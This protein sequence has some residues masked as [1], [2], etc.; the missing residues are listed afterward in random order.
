MHICLPYIYICKNTC[1]YL[2][3]IYYKQTYM[4]ICICVCTGVC[5]SLQRCNFEANACI[6]FYFWSH[7][8]LYLHRWLKHQKNIDV[9]VEPRVR[10]ELLLDD[11]SYSFVQTWENGQH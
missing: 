5:V 1:I 10:N 3:S 6:V 8:S 7:F 4:H 9:L 11:S 2:F